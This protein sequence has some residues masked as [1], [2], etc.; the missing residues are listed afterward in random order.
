MP[1]LQEPLIKSLFLQEAFLPKKT[2]LLPDR[3]HFYS[4]SNRKRYRRSLRHINLLNKSVNQKFR[5]FATHLIKPH[6]HNNLVWGE[7]IPELPLALRGSFSTN[8]SP[9]ME[10]AVSHLHSFPSKHITTAIRDNPS[11][12]KPSFSPR[13]ASP[14]SVRPKAALLSYITPRLVKNSTGRL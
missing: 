4:Y 7:V 8:K 11:P 1:F 5:T 6:L 10:V 13:A 12:L 2:F 14:Q 3:Q 9:L